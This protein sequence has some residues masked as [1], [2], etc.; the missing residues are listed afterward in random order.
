ME[1]EINTFHDKQK[2]KEFMTSTAKCTKRNATD[3][4]TIT[5]KICE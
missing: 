2:L 1:G 4:N 3:M 5:M